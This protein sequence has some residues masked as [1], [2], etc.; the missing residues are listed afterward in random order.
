MSS[1][2]EIFDA[3]IE[4]KEADKLDEAVGKLE[5][6]I[7]QEPGFVL[8]HAGL[9]VCYG[10]LE[11][12]DEAVEHAQK[13]CELDPEDPFSFMAKSIVCQKAGRMQEAEEALARAMEM[14]WAA[15]RK[16]QP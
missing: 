5:E 9:S 1:A 15:A 12:H 10:A 6:L 13:V 8:A 2:D 4:L 3:A 7:G 14:Q 11:R 16:A